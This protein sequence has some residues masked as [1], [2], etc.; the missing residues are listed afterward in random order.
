MIRNAIQL[1]VLQIKDYVKKNV[2]YFCVLNLCINSK[3]GL[4][5]RQCRS[6]APGSY[7]M[8]SRWVVRSLLASLCSV[9]CLVVSVLSLNSPIVIAWEGSSE[10]LDLAASYKI[11]GLD[12][13]IAYYESTIFPSRGINSDPGYA[14]L[15]GGQRNSDH[16]VQR[17]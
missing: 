8:Q 16:R 9:C 1:I 5:E 13:N 3:Q 12:I 4:A 17:A 2:I 14:Q 10:A 15:G 6:N 11:E 7:S